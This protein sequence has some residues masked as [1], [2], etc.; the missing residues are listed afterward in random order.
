MLTYYF[1]KVIYIEQGY[2]SG[3]SSSP[4]VLVQ[5]YEKDREDTEHLGLYLGPSDVHPWKQGILS[6]AVSVIIF[7][8]D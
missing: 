6:R 3:S 7:I 8:T 2:S 1:F 5:M 4:S